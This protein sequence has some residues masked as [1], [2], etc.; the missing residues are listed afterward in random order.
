[1][2]GH[3]STPMQ[4]EIRGVRVRSVGRG[5][6]EVLPLRLWRFAPLLTGTGVALTLLTAAFLVGVLLDPREVMGA[7][8]WLKPA[9]FAISTGIYALTFAWMLTHVRGRPTLVRWAGR[10]TAW[11]LVV[12]VGLIALQA[13][14]GTTSHFNQTTLLNGWITAT[15]GVAILA[16]WV[17]SIAVAVALLRQ[18]FTDRALAAS[19]RSG[20]WITIAGAAVGIYM[21]TPSAEQWQTLRSGVRPD[22]IGA[23]SVGGVDGGP[24]LTAVGWST[25]HG[26]LRVA[27]FVGLHAMQVIPLVGWWLA[28]RGASQRRR[29]AL[30]RV[31]AASYAGLVA[32]ALVQALRAQPVTRPDAWTLGLVLFWAALTV[33]AVRHA[34][35]PEAGWA[36]T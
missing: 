26:D 2:S 7:P 33:A 5:R 23:H 14:R 16:L 34:R 1:M 32:I 9:K 35:A 4:A 11:V 24:G 27:H 29:L 12:E 17:M 28:R 13:G 25:E 3:T 20:L 31:A 21:A 8:R 30:V 18:P 19:L 22:Y 10:I 6:A 36:T 15:T